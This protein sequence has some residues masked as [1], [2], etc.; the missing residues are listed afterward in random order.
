M[1]QKTQKTVQPCLNVTCYPYALGAH[2]GDD[3]LHVAHRP[4]KPGVITQASSLLQPKDRLE[5]SPF[6]Y[7]ETLEVS[8]ITLDDWKKKFAMDI[9]LWHRI[10]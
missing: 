9:L 1:F 2:T 6:I 4:N 5:W 10:L 8:S 7:P 3:T